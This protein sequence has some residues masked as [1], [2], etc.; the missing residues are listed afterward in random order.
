VETSNDLVEFR[1]A[2]QN[3]QTSHGSVHKML[4]PTL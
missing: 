2:G 3:G 1:L 4:H